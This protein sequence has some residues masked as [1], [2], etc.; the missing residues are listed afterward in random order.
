M[1]PL[2][3]STVRQTEKKVISK[4]KLDLSKQWFSGFCR[5]HFKL[6]VVGCKGQGPA[7]EEVNIRTHSKRF[8]GIAM[9]CKTS[10]NV[11]DFIDASKQEQSG[12]MFQKGM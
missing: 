1:L 6:T 10:K 7:E 9:D 8:G 4:S 3:H 5:F 12:S 11:R 2:A